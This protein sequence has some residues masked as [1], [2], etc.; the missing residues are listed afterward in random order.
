[1]PE[2]KNRKPTV[3]TH[4]QLTPNTVSEPTFPSFWVAI[5]AVKSVTYASAQSHNPKVVGSNP[6]PATDRTYQPINLST[7]KA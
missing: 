7:S 1:M 6:T 5:C 3:E 2:S 4:S